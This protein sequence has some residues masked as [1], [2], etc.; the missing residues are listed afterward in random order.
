MSSPGSPSLSPFVRGTTDS[1]LV[2]ELSAGTRRP[3]PDPQTLSFLLA[4]QTVRVLSDA[5]LAAIPLGAGLPSRKDGVLVTQ[6]FAAP[7]PAIVAYFMANGQR[8]KIPDLDTQLLFVHAGTQIVQLEL[9]DLTAIPEGPALPTRKDGTLY[10]GAGKA[11]AYLMQNGQKLA[12]PDATTLRDGGHD[13][14][15]LLPI[16]AG[17]LSFIP[18]GTA[19]PT[20]SRFLSPPPA[21]VPLVLLPVRLE[22]RIQNNELWLRVYPDDLHV[23]SFEPELTADE[24]TARTAYLALAQADAE[25]RRAA[26]AGLARQFGTARSAWIASAG[27][28][29]AIKPADW[30]LAPSTNVLPERWI[31]IGYQGNAP[32]QVLAVG[33]PITDPLPL[34]PLPGGSGPAADAGTKWVTDFASA[35]QAGMAFRITLSAFRGQAYTRLLVLGLRTGLNPQDSAAR[36]AELLQA[37]HYTDGL[38]LL[39]HNT[40]TNNTEDVSSGLSS[41]DPDYAKLFALE[42]GPPLC[43]ARPTADGDRLARALNIPPA[44]LAHISGADG[45]QDEQARAMNTVLWPAT[46]GYYLSQIVAGP[47]PNPAVMLPAARDHFA[48]H[49]RARG[50]FPA[51]RI[52]RQPYGILPVCWN[53]SWQSLEGRALDAPL[54]SLLQ[55]LRTFWGQC[56]FNVPRIPNSPDPEAALVSLL[57]MTPASTSSIARGVIGPEYTFA[58]W[59]YVGND[60]TPAWW[61]KLAQKALVDHSDLAASMAN[62]RLASA[63]YVNWHRPLSDV[64]AGPDPVGFV[65]QLAAMGGWQALLDATLPAPIPVLFLLLRHAALRVYLDT[66][67]DLLTAAK[68]LQPGEGIE[69]EMVG[70]TGIALRPTAWDLL[71]R[72][73]QGRGAVG[74]VL[75]G[76]RN[77]ATLPAFVSFWQAF[78]QLA[79]YSA[80]DLDAATREVLD[81]ASYRL[82]AWIASLAHFRLDQT[83]TANPNGGIVLGA[84]GWLENISLLPQL[85]PSQGYVHAPSLNQSTTAAVLR[86]GYLAHQG[87]PQK[88]FE[89]DLS[90]ARVRLALHILDGIREGQSLGALLGYRL[91]RTLHDTQL[92]AL[93]QPLRNA[94]PTAAASQLD[95][96]D[97]LALLRQFHSDQQQFWTAVGLSPT[98]AP[99]GTGLNSAITRL[100]DALDS[101]ADLALAESVHQLTRG[102]TLRAGAALDSI[103]RGDTPPPEID[104]VQTPRS[105]AALTY[106]LMTVAIGNSAPGWTVTPRAQAEPRLNAWAAALLGDPALVR[107]RARFVNADGSSPAN[108]EIGLQ[109]LALAPVDLLSFPETAGIAGE[110]ADRIRRVVQLARPASVPADAQIELVPDRDPA[111]TTKT[112]GLTEWLGLLQG[113][114]RMTGG[115]RAIEPADLVLQGD[116]PG[117]IDTAELQSRADAAE[118][119]LRAALAALSTATNQDGALLGAAAFG[120]TGAVPALDPSVWP[121]QIAAASAELSARAQALDNLAAGFVRGAASADSPRDHDVARLQAIFGTS[122]AVLPVL[123]PG[124]A[125]N[126]PQLWANSLSLQGGDALASIRWMQR[127]SRVR[128][129]A[130]RMDTALMFAEALAGRPLLQLQVAQ[131]PPAATDR[132]VALD[133][134][135]GPAPSRLSLVAFSPTPFAAGAPVAGLMVDEWVEVWPSTEQIT[136]VSF[137]Y[138]DPVARAPQAILLAVRPDDFPEWTLAAVE[139]SVLEAL[140]LARTRGVDPDVLLGTVP[141]LEV[142]ENV[143][144]FQAVSENEVFVLGGDGNLWLEHAPFGT[145]PPTRDHVDANVSAF[146]ALSDTEVLVLGSDGRLWLE[147]APF[148]TVPPTRQ[149][150]DANVALGPPKPPPPPP[151]T[152]TVPDVSDLSAS[153]ATKT[154]QAAKLVAK[155]NGPTQ[156]GALVVS[157]SPLAGT[158]V[159]IGSTVTAVMRT[160]LKPK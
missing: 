8:R 42:Q 61:T 54:H 109:Q 87:G 120:V 16:T 20:T 62:T 94:F 76:S 29:S 118:T 31:V 26:F 157:Q 152:A 15:A 55:Q 131:L 140:D 59:N 5:D 105:G 158:V 48:D 82:D 135:A 99:Q 125:A 88:P 64:L 128:A 115:A 7:P 58:Y 81:L 37:H 60:L 106:R 155:L 98:S 83:R 17:D 75:D 108:V 159:P 44:T 107:I 144:A 2:Y 123:A 110:L 160:G 70:F 27:P 97:G 46:W 38:E 92:D 90:S 89:I 45:A 156:A 121:A 112:I 25:T 119:Q 77:D 149:Q 33:P 23:N 113:I 34:G 40:P 151:T 141:P 68:A 134:P 36:L 71:G 142:D 39:P 21:Q 72:D 24:Q 91:E 80:A 117:A 18:D 137:Q 146:Q 148:G 111:W 95:V 47:V 127:A 84:Y 53:A 32:G 100:F 3:I 126:W 67:L 102:N 49:V 14:H 19:F 6:K 86:S 57:G 139:G 93:I 50:H 154:I 153:I 12:F 124:L 9:A 147:H 66:A 1:S 43:P 150:V 52:G 122:F 143:K 4:G 65:G 136:G 129:G 30:T 63:T 69:A 138:S 22:T 85:P 145:V 41:K 133:A 78:T 73:L 96:V 79:G 10:Q 103:A 56:I 130:A 132:W 13:F 51:V 114:T 74:T 116:P 101:V 11:F 104:F 35:I 28:S